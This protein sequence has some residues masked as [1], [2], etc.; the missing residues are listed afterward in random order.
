VDLATLLVMSHPVPLA[1]L[2]VAQQ[3]LLASL[4]LP[5]LLPV[6][7]PGRA[8]MPHWVAPLLLFLQ[9]KLHCSNACL[10]SQ[11]CS[12]LSQLP[13]LL[14]LLLLPM[15]PLCRQ[16][17][18]LHSRLSERWPVLPQACCVPQEHSAALGPQGLLLLPAVDSQVSPPQLQPVGWPVWGWGL[19]LLLLLGS[20][21]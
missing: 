3:L 7:N 2:V 8:V 21:G 15:Q 11:G 1:H 16:L 20:G 9:P 18:L 19:L 17:L 13:L 14:P 6:V 5:L 10:V 4:L 12:H